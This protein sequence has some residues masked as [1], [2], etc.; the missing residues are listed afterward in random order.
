MSEKKLNPRYVHMWIE[1]ATIVFGN[2][3]YNIMWS[4]VHIIHILAV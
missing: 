4:F 2:Y 1:I 3:D